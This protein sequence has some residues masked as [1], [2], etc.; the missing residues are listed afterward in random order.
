MVCRNA[1]DCL[2]GTSGSDRSNPAWQQVYRSVDH[3]FARNQCRNAAVMR[4]FPA[5]IA[6]FATVFVEFQEQRHAADYDPAARFRRS[7]TLLDLS[8]AESALAAFQRTPLKDRRAFAAWV[9][10]RARQG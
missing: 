10:L 7:Q 2:I 1:A 9:T 6:H 5:E 8:R 3:G 4:R